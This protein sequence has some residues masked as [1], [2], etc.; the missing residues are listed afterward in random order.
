MLDSTRG[1]AIKG[2]GTGKTRRK[3]R[4]S[5]GGGRHPRRTFSP[6]VGILLGRIPVVDPWT[7]Q[8][9]LR[10]VRALENGP[11]SPL[12][13][14]LLERRRESGYARVWGR[15]GRIGGLQ[16]RRG[17]R[18]LYS[19]RARHDTQEGCWCVHASRVV[20][21][22]LMILPQVHLRK[23]CYDFYFLEIIKFDHLPGTTT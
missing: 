19:E 16:V 6:T 13:D 18:G 4:Q 8:A 7:R 21:V 2:F 22:T 5:G 9:S 15:P 14:P 20:V 10:R 11:R 3:A 1:D 12:F 23:P 17:G